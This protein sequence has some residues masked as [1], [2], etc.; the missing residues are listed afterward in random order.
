MNKFWQIDLRSFLCR[1]LVSA[2]AIITA[3]SCSP[4]GGTDN[5]WSEFVDQFTESYF[6]AHPEFAVY[7]GRH[8]FDG[9]LPDT[10]RLGVAAEVER[11]R[12]Q[13]RKAVAFFESR[14][15]AEERF[16]R[17]YIVSVIDRDLYWLDSAR[18]PFWNPAFYVDALEPSTYVTREYASPDVRMAA[19]TRYVGEVPRILADARANL[20]MP[21]ARTL[22]Q[23]GI[24]SFGGYA[25]YYKKDV[26]VAFASVT[27]PKLQEQFAAA[28]GKA[29]AALREFTD[30]LKAQLPSAK[31]SFALGPVLFAT[32]VRDTEGV[33]IPLEDLEAAGRADLDR[34]LQALREAC[35]EYL[36][37]KTI[38]ECI[39]KASAKKPMGGTVAAATSQLPVLRAF[40]AAH[41]LVS[42]PGTEAAKVAE[43][44]PYA[45]S[46]FA[47][48]NIPG[49]YEKNLPS[50]YYVA[51]PDKSWSAAEQAAY[52]PSQSTL[53][54]TSVHE[55]WPG[56]FLQ[57][58]H[59]NRASWRF[60]Q[61]FVG[62]AFAEGWAHYAEEMMW[63]AGLGAGDPETHIGQLQQ[64]LTRDVRYLCAIAIHA[65]EL[66][67]EHCEKMFREQAYRDPG[68]ARQQAAR[69]VYD[70]AYLNYTLGKL[71]IRKLRTDWIAS[72]GGRAAWKEFHD[73]FLSYGGPPIPLVR[74]QMLGNGSG[75]LLEIPKP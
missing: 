22:L 47:F 3:S 38:E 21:L 23:Y 32:M 62:Y 16:Q 59:S 37:G 18:R 72:R 7:S 28:N 69:G 57:F 42:I 53:L 43:S 12:A 51:P 36:K 31:P 58:L 64:A 65:R 63:E 33:T 70:P 68:N 60:G 19:F 29:I 40:I 1:A 15:G 5:H 74:K 6:K 45:R 13:R 9:Q 52:V 46:N 27:D 20:V 30:Y 55:V 67:P 17:D 35:V 34:N 26:P 61:L 11:L 56:H 14:L 50:I 4:R 41:D 73:Q 54:F 66:P 24:D 8:E 39:A 71:M 2:V 25:D 10:S 75:D 48:I 49:P 44:P